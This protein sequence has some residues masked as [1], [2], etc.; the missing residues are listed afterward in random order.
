MTLEQLQTNTHNLLQDNKD[1]K[2]ENRNL[3]TEL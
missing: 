3:K 1:L 2:K